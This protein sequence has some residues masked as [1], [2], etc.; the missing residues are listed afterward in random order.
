MNKDNNDKKEDFDI[1]I[2][3]S[4]LQKTI[5]R[6]MSEGNDLPFKTEVHKPLPL[7][8]F[9]FMG[10]ISEKMPNTNKTIKTIINYYLKYMISFNRKGRGE[11]VEILKNRVIEDEQSD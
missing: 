7:A 6:L 9:D 10:D 11:I 5:D 4:D 3:L 1:G 8:V 2:I